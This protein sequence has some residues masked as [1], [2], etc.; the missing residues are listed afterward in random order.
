MKKIDKIMYTN[1]VSLIIFP[2]LLFYL[3]FVN[4]IISIPLSILTIYL[5]YKLIKNYSYQ[6]VKYT[7]KYWIIAGTVI[8]LWLFFSG[9]GDF[10]FQNHDFHFRHAI[11]R[12]L[13]NYSWPVHYEKYSFSYY[14]SYF[15]PSA[16][17][18]KITNYRIANIFFVYLFL[19]LYYEYFVFNKQI[20][21][22]RIILGFI[23]TNAF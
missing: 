6:E 9:I 18:G 19:Y 2:V 12:D 10:S 1:S 13:V 5:A 15:L 20:F 21:K 3:G 14:F 7:K 11:L 22:K 4:F 23:S 17:I 16:L 8:L